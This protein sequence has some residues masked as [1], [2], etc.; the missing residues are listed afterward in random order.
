MPEAE[1]A[2]EALAALTEELIA[3]RKEM[4]EVFVKT[5]NRMSSTCDELDQ[6]IRAP[7]PYVSKFEG[8]CEIETP[9]P[10]DGHMVRTSE[11]VKKRPLKPFDA[12][13]V[14]FLSLIHI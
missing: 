6:L 2:H 14:P 12:R 4:A 10:R 8:D 13:A 9:Y 3:K 5:Q 11:V 7:I 1:G